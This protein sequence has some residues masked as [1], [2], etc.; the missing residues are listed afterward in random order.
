MGKKDSLFSR[1]CWE[2][3]TAACKSMKLEDTLTPCTKI[4]S[5]WLKY[6]NKK[7]D[8]INLLEKN[9]GEIF[10]DS[11]RTNVFSGQSPKAIEIK[12]KINH[13]YL[14]KL[15]SFCAAKETIKKEKDKLHKIV[16][17]DATDK[18]LISKICKLMQL[19]SKKT[20]NPIEKWAE[21]V[22]RYFL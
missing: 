7:Q 12:T 3:W 2:N 16:A 4:N 10:S 14:I 21:D 13:W 15:T 5:K 20:N 9:T 6:L 17:N 8:T 19:N 22:N 1:W 18:S 11:N